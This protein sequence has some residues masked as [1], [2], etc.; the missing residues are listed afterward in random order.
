MNPGPPA[1]Q[2]GVII[3]TRRRALQTGLYKNADIIIKT[4][5]KLRA[6]G[7]DQ[8]T[9]YQTEYQL[10]EINEK[11]D[12]FNPEEVKKYISNRK[13]KNGEKTANSYR[14]NLL[15]GYAYF[16]SVN[17]IQWERP[18]FHYERKIPRI[19]TT[20]AV[21]KIISASTRKYATIFT[22]LTETGFEGKELE[23]TSRDDIDAEQGIINVQGCKAHNSRPIKLI[24]H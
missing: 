23:R 16:A 15:K 10:I 7:L 5:E 11:S 2:A 1:P 22:L 13:N 3:R 19:P 21:T 17:G 24:F 20:E 18:Y 8:G 9:L 14:N 12:L 6:S 4:L